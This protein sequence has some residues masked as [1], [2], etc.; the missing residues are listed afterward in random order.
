MYLDLKL[1]N[2]DESGEIEWK[3]W[4]VSILHFLV[5]WLDELRPNVTFHF[6]GHK[7]KVLLLH[8]L[9]LLD[10]GQEIDQ[11]VQVNANFHFRQILTGVRFFRQFDLFES[12]DDEWN[13]K[14]EIRSSVLNAST[15]EEYG[16]HDDLLYRKI[17]NV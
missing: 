5:M 12:V 2:H 8:V 3:N 15:R 9:L 4:I 14:T 1:K 11:C 17:F 7:R 16:G 13:F 10:A 6:G